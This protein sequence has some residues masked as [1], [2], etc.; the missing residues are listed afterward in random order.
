VKTDIHFDGA[1]SSRVAPA[2]LVARH[3]AAC[4]ARNR[5]GAPECYG[6]PVD[7]AADTI[8][9]SEIFES[10]QG[11]GP[12][13]GEP[14]LFVRLALCNLRCE[15]C[16]TRYTWDFARYKYDEEVREQPVAEVVSRILSSRVCRVIL[17]GGEPLV[18]AAALESVLAQIP[19]ETSVEVETNGTLM[20]SASLTRRVDQWNVSP[21]LENSG[22]SLHR[23]RKLDVLRALLAT[24]R[25]YLKLVVRSEADRDEAVALIDEL[26]W[27][28]TRVCLMPE[29]PTPSLHAERAPRVAA[30]SQSLGVRFSPRL[31]VLLWGGERGR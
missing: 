12:S 5:R 22:E 21:K 30:M 4:V 14:A 18:Q 19:A 24:E 29:A 10:I 11:E 13:L 8:K 6:P 15:W 7:S 16:D 25:A 27:P 17:T 20:P 23:R 31:H 2:T 1:E 28:R 9:I 3:E 26:A